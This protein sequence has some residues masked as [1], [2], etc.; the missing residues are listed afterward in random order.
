MSYQ[1]AQPLFF[2]LSVPAQVETAAGQVQDEVRRS[3]GSPRLPDL[4]DLHVSLAYMGRLDFSI[5]PV[6]L[7]LAEVTAAR[8]P[9]FTLRAAGLGGFPRMGSAR[10]LWLGFTPEPALDALVA[11]L[12]AALGAAHIGFDGKPFHP[13]MTL[14][15]FREPVAL[16]R[17]ALSEPEPV[18]FEVREFGLFQSVQ[19]PGG[20][21]Y[22]LLGSVPL[23]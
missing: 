8:H 10:V 3:I 1:I 6:L 16:E 14:A 7:A 17:V 19:A 18:G 23:A 12:W 20:N 5:V 4:D 11:D 21:H 2:A 22:R 13:H 9:R 15:R